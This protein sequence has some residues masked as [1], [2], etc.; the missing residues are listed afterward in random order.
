MRIRWISLKNSRRALKLVL[1]ALPALLVVVAGAATTYVTV[2]D[3]LKQER[4]AI[5]SGW[6]N[7][8]QAIQERAALIRELAEVERQSGVAVD[9]IAR[10]VAE[11]Q[12]ELARFATPEQRIRAHDR[13]SMALARLLE[14]EDTRQTNVGRKHAKPATLRLEDQLKD[15]EEKIAVARRKYNETLE[16][17]NTRIQ[18]FPNNLVAKIAGFRRN[19]AYFR[20]EPF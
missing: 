6:E 16:H 5:G 13:L 4:A 17:Y 2:R 11:T 3:S 7:V 15:S 9:Q 18:T 1:V 14:A 8:D 19:D 10:E 20:T 12:S